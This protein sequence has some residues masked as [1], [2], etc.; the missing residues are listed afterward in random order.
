MP[1]IS[2]PRLGLEVLDLGSRRHRRKR[3]FLIVARDYGLG[4][5]RRNGRINSL[6]NGD[7]EFTRPERILAHYIFAQKAVEI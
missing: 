4:V 6:D 5:A 2:R 1:T 7:V 3:T